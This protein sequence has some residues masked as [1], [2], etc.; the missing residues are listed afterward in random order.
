[1]SPARSKKK[2]TAESQ[3]DGSFTQQCQEALASLNRLL[4]VAPHL[5]FEEVDITERE[6]VRLRDDLIDR[7]R[8][9]STSQEAGRLRAALE[10]VN[11]AVSLVA[12]VE[13][14]GAGIQQR[15]LEGAQEALKTAL[16][17]GL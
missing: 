13:Y 1:M 12:G 10:H 14:P 8:Q 2:T 5:R 4:E 11:A 3:A 16:A 15:L 6:I 17:Q 7:L 9:D